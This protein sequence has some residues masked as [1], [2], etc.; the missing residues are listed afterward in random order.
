MGGW[1]SLWF[2]IDVE[3]ARPPR[4]CRLFATVA[5]A[6]LLPAAHWNRDRLTLGEVRLGSWLCENAIIRERSGS[7]ARRFMSATPGK[8]T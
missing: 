8:R 5:G 1:A 7:L 3:S 6:P 4:N 2:E